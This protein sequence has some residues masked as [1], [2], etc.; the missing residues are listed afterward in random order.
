MTYEEIVLKVREGFEYADA[1]DIFEHIAVQVNIVGEGSGAFYIEVAGRYATVE[2]YDYVDRDGLLTA[3]AQTLIDIAMGKLSAE[4]AVKSGR[5]KVE[6][7]MDK[8]R[9]FA[10]IKIKKQK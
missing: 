8:L 7:N 2:P 9:L 10:K 1:R 5:L 3:D 6:G 4:D